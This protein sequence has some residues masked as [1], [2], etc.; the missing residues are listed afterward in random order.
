MEQNP[1]P[2]ARILLPLARKTCQTPRLQK[3]NSLLLQEQYSYLLLVSS[4][5]F[6][7]TC[8][9]FKKEK[10]REKEKREEGRENKP[11]KGSV[12]GVALSVKHVTLDFS[13]GHDFMVPEIKCH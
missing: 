4:P 1:I 10:K 2:Q 6:S 9:S 11:K 7:L 3:T 12:P 8:L 13:S 5:S